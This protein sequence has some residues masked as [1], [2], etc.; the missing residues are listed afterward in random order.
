MKIPKSGTLEDPDF[1]FCVKLFYKLFANLTYL[2][3][4]QFQTCDI[5]SVELHENV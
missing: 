5:E 3:F 4:H 1:V 2:L